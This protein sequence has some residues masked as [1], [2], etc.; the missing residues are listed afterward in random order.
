MSTHARVVR[1]AVTCFVASVTVARAQVPDHLQCFRVKDPQPK[2]RYTADVGGL[3]AGP[4]CLIRVP[5]K[6]A[7]VP[8]T[9]TNVNPAPPGGGPSATATAVLCY[10][11]KCEPS[12]VPELGLQDQ[13]GSRVLQLRKASLLCAPAGPIPTTTV[14]TTVTTLPCGTTTTIPVCGTTCP[15]FC[16]GGQQCVVGTGGECSC[17]GP[18]VP[19]DRNLDNNFCGLG[20]CPPGMQCG[21]TSGGTCGHNCGCQ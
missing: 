7:C 10:A 3:S 12:A 16:P 19:C 18:S 21:F 15:G 9:K 20:E 4:G 1:V 8:A 2:V 6:L 11:V 13:F 17:V 14:T 5:A